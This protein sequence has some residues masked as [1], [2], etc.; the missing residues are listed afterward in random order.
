M[1]LIRESDQVFEVRS[2]IPTGRRVLFVLFAFFPLYVP[3]E[4]LIKTDWNTYFSVF[5]L[6]AA[7]ISLGALALS[8]FLIWAAVVGLTIRLRFDRST[9]TFTYSEGAST[10]RWRKESHSLKE[11]AEIT[12]VEQDWSDGPSSYAAAV[13]LRDGKTFQTGTFRSKEEIEEIV[14]EAS[15]LLEEY[16]K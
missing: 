4:L 2:T 8:G 11:V 15:R 16:K 9:Q 12:T 1:E 7:L 10:L 14:G 5:F 6:F 3:Y 13:M